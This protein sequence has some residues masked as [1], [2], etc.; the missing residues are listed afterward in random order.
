LI[1]TARLKYFAYYCWL[2]ALFSVVYIL[3]DKV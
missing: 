1:Q 2:V 3:S